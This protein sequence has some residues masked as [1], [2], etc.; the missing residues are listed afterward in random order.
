M[1][2]TYPEQECKQSGPCSDVRDRHCADCKKPIPDFREAKQVDYRYR[3]NAGCGF[4]SH[5]SNHNHF[6]NVK[7]TTGISPVKRELCLEC[8]LE[9]WKVF[10]PG[11]PLP[12]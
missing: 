4:Q 2:P 8:Y 9:D 6:R 10:Y 7:G 12:F 1:V 11:V 5:T 3:N